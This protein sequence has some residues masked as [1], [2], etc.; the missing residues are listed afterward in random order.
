MKERKRKENKQKQIRTRQREEEC[1]FMVS[2][3]VNWYGQC[4]SR[5]GGFWE[6]RNRSPVRLGY[7]LL[8]MSLED[9]ILPQR[10][11]YLHVCCS[12]HNSKDIKSAWKP[13]GSGRCID[14]LATQWCFS[15]LFLYVILFMCNEKWNLQ[16]NRVDLEVITLC[17]AT[18]TQKDS[19]RFSQRQIPAFDV[20]VCICVGGNVGRNAWSKKG[21]TRRAKGVLREGVWEES[22]ERTIGVERYSWEDGQRTGG[23]GDST[24]M[25]YVWKCHNKTHPFVQ[26]HKSTLRSVSV[27]F[28]LV[29]F[30]WCLGHSHVEILRPPT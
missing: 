4:G 24:K 12:S 3:S 13:I 8:G 2:G 28:T 1:W 9:C 14:G 16:G 18:Q 15:N 26:Q 11:L 21:T 5:C 17:E 7:P 23:G 25:D 30:L 6:P 22:G 20:S 19:T 10:C 27:N 29:K